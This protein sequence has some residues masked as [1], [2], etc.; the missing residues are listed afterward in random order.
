MK[1]NDLS[2]TEWVFIRVSV[3]TI[4]LF[5]DDE[6]VAKKK[7]EKLADNISELSVSYLPSGSRLAVF[8]A[9]GELVAMRVY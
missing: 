2:F 1:R 8:R 7:I 9:K 3:R 6:V 4:L 5:T